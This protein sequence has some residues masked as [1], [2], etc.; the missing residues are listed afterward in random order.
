M[1]MDDI[2]PMCADAKVAIT[3]MLPPQK[4]FINGKAQKDYPTGVVF[5]CNTGHIE[6]AQMIVN[7]YKNTN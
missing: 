4:D 5:L 2:Y 3:G 7:K 1:D 6:E